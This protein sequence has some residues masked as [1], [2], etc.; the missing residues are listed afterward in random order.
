MRRQPKS[1]VT[2]DWLPPRRPSVR[3]VKRVLAVASFVLAVAACSGGEDSSADDAADVLPLSMVQ[4]GEFS[5][6]VLRFE[7]TDT[8]GGN[9]GAVEIRAY[10]VS[11]P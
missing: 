10:G 9:T 6:R 1:N 11:A 3:V 7:L 4:V 8:T 2:A 5:G